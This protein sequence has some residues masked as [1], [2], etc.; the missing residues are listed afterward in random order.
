MILKT[1]FLLI[2]NDLTSCYY[3]ELLENWEKVDIDIMFHNFTYLYHLLKNLA[4]P[5]KES[6][7][8]VGPEVS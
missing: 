8:Q 4:A 1:L 5:P 2:P 7:S 3:W 6:I